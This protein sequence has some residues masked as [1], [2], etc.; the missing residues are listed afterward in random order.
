MY[1]NDVKNFF[2]IIIIMYSKNVS[3]FLV[4]VSG[5]TWI[6]RKGSE[7]KVVHTMD[8]TFAIMSPRTRRLHRGRPDLTSTVLSNMTASNMT[9][10]TTTPST[11]QMTSFSDSSFEAEFGP[12]PDE[13]IINARGRR[14]LPLTFSPDVHCTPPRGM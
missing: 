9:N 10:M 7:K 8:N 2:L 12:S 5:V 1:D 11:A 14:A 3:F 6:L 13:L 4:S